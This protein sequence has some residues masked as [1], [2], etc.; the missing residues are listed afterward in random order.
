MLLLYNQANLQEGWGLK[1]RWPCNSCVL[2]ALKIIPDL[3]SLLILSAVP[4]NERG[5]PRGG[6]NHDVLRWRNWEPSER[7]FSRKCTRLRETWILN[8]AMLT[9]FWFWSTH[10]KSLHSF[11][12]HLDDKEELNS[13]LAEVFL[14]LIDMIKVTLWL[15]G[16]PSREWFQSKILLL[17]LWWEVGSYCSGLTS[18]LCSLL[19]LGKGLDRPGAPQMHTVLCWLYI[20]TGLKGST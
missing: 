18:V 5:G 15:L 10:L 6:G 19:V 17:F 7:Q 8:I 9:A 12:S 14:I 1:R 11:Y 16:D 3:L 13:S 20:H 4:W 2:L